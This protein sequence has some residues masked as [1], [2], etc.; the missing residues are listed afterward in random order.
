MEEFIKK[1]SSNERV[2]GFDSCTKAMEKI[3]KELQKYN[4]KFEED[5]F[6]FTSWENYK[7]EVF[8]DEEKIE[9]IFV[10]WSGSGIASGQAKRC[11]FEKTFNGAYFF[12]K[13][14]I[15][16]NAFLISSNTKVWMQPLNNPNKKDIF[17]MIFPKDLKKLENGEIKNVK[18]IS[19]NKFY[20]SKSANLICLAKTKKNKILLTAHYDSVKN[21]K[22][23]NDNA[24]GVATL[25]EIIKKI[26]QNRNEYIFFSAEEWNLFGSKHWAKNILKNNSQND[27]S[28]AIN[29]DMLASNEGELHF[30]VNDNNLKKQL[31]SIDKN[32]KISK[33]IGSQWDSFSISKLGIKTIQ[34]GAYPYSHCH[35]K[36]DTAEKLDFKKIYKVIEIL[37]KLFRII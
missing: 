18:I 1:F 24:S 3:K 9:S 30:F 14:Q 19:K 29:F 6:D 5:Y 33:E 37:K 26:D 13:F 22:G 25:F 2:A 16:E 36:T 8:F 12:K 11:G 32:L 21:S 23:A 7:T 35:F 34:I 17:A 31:L 27:F 20:N 15:T 10:P 4:K 28:F